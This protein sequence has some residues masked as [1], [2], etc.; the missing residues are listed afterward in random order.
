MEQ[1]LPI[2]WRNFFWK[3]TAFDYNWH[4]ILTMYT[5]TRFWSTGTASDFG[6]KFVQNYLN[7]KTFEKINIKIAVSIQNNVPLYEISVIL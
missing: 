5:N 2:F 1:N 3:I 6:T 4:V 7:D